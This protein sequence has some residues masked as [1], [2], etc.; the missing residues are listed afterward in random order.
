[1][2]TES[3]N[4]WL[5]LVEVSKR[6]YPNWKSDMS[7]A[8][9]GDTPDSRTYVPN[10]IAMS[11]SQ[12]FWDSGD[13]YKFRSTDMV[14]RGDGQYETRKGV[15]TGT[16]GLLQLVDKFKFQHTNPSRVLLIGAIT[17][18][19]L[20]CTLEF[21][22]QR[23]WDAEVDLI[24]LS[25]VPLRHIDELNRLGFFDG[26]PKFKLFQSSIQN[27][28]TKRYDVV[29]GD[30]LNV[31]AVPRFSRYDK[32]PYDGFESILKSSKSR[33]TKRGIFYSRCV[34]YPTGSSNKNINS[35]FDVRGQALA[36]YDQLSEL[37]RNVNFQFIEDCLQNLFVNATPKDCCGL[38]AVIPEFAEHPTL[39]GQNAEKQ[40]MGL[41]KN[42]FREVDMIK[43]LDL[44]S[45][46]TYLNFA[47]RN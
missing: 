32:N 18:K 42:L 14:R 29:L 38:D 2:T 28:D 15:T 21:A 8:S 34:V 6:G 44:K 20:M 45:G 39:E 43:V 25:E 47:C 24:D 9:Y 31:W 46:A 41:H 4:V 16:L 23:H 30:I 10:Y 12:R 40:M 7:G 37:N 36:V 33:L 1:M 19:S 13:Q 27:A 35:R 17:D 11:G 5:P 26:S 3:K 22:N